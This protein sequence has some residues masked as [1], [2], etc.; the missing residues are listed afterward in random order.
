MIT[1]DTVFIDT[2]V[3]V[4]E[5]YFAAGNRINSLRRMAEEGKIKL[6]LSE[7]TIEEVRR[8]I[9]SQVRESWKQFDKVCKVF[10]NRKEIDDWRKG[11][12]DKKECERYLS[13]LEDFLKTPNLTVL[14]YS[15]CTDTAKVFTA[16]FARKKPFGEGMK[17][18]E[19]PDAFVLAA[20]EKYAAETKHPIVVLSQDSDMLCYESKMLSCQECGGYVSKKLKEG[21]ALQALD[22]ILKEEKADLE[23]EIQKQAVDYLD[24]F[25]VY[26]S[27]LHMMD[28]TDHDV[29]KVEVD[30]DVKNYD[31]VGISDESIEVE[32]HP[33]VVFTVNVYYADYDFAQ[34]DRED[35]VWYGIENR[36][37]EVNGSTEVN[38]VLRLYYQGA[39]EKIPV[40]EIVDLDLAPLMD[41]IE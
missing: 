24:D 27:C 40:F 17:K 13:H 26:L 22:E 36:V 38:L 15:Y 14:D 4:A 3:F 1:P 30:L 11:T 41:V 19:F 23:K 35:G 5:N 8:H 12:N 20:L 16:Y 2:S 33:E 34:Y 6:V 29:E 39:C 18:D 25:R 31:V 32:L 7:I 9:V 21:V 37:Y 28:V 10:R